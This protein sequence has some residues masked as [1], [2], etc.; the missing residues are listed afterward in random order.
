MISSAIFPP[1]LK[2]DKRKF[3]FIDCVK[4]LSSFGDIYPLLPNSQPFRPAISFPSDNFTTAYNLL[5]E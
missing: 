4:S 5:F 2:S 1:E 3:D